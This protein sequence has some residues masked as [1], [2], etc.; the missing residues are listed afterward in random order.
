MEVL[1]N[2]FLRVYHRSYIYSLDASDLLEKIDLLVA[3]SLST[4][5]SLFILINV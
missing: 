5:V 4:E 1:S 2:E 3:E